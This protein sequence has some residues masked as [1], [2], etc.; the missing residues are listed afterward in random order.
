MQKRT[1]PPGLRSIVQKGV[2]K[3][4][5]PHQR[6]S[7]SGSVHALKTSA[8][9]ASNTR[10]MTSSRCAVSPAA[11][12][13]VTVSCAVM[14]LAV[15]SPPVRLLL[16]QIVLQAIQV[17][18]PETAIVLEPIGGVLER[19][20]LQ[21][22][23]PPLRLATAGDQPGALQHLQVLGDGGKAHREGLRQLRDRR[24]ARA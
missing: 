14:S 13:L 12:L 9:G 7:R 19:T 10:V 16:A 18:L 22:A 1:A 15:M 2:V 11:L 4:C 6:T 21:L 17:L 24:L 23:G 3:P 5:G 20:R 8:R